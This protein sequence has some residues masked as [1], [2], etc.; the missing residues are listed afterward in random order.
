MTIKVVYHNDE[1]DEVEPARL[2]ELI[3]SHKIKKFLRTKGWATVGVDPVRGAR[4]SYSGPERRGR[5]G[6][7]DFL[8][9]DLWH[10]TEICI[11]DRSKSAVSICDFETLFESAPAMML[12]LNPDFRIVAASNAYLQHTNTRREDI[13]DHDVFDILPA[14]SGDPK[15]SGNRGLRV[16]LERVL[17]S[18]KPHAM[19]MQ[20]HALPG[21]G[22]NG[23][24][25]GKRYWNS[26]N[27]PV[28][29]PDNTVKYIIHRLEDITR[30]EHLKA[31]A[32][33]QH[34]LIEAL[35][36]F[37]IQVGSEF[38]AKAREAT[39]N[40]LHLEDVIARLERENDKLK[41]LVES[42]N[43][44]IWFYDQRDN[45]LHVNPAIVNHIGLE[46]CGNCG[47]E[48]VLAGL[49]IYHPNGTPR[50]FEESPVYRA[51]IEREVVSGEEIVRHL[52]TGEPRYRQ[53]TAAPMRDDTGLV[54]GAVAV[55][56][57][58]TEQ[59][60]LM[61]ELQE[62]LARAKLLSGMLPI[63]SS[64]KRIKDDKGIWTHVE[65]YI[66]DHSQADFT[67]SLCPDCARKLYPGIFCDER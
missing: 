62:K 33:E 42:V 7:A 59:R 31:K 46:L 1:T 41:V 23:K 20:T 15:P 21:S 47:L 13:I 53:Y 17:R 6:Q 61:L 28:L 43:D 27:T 49:E 52:K 54:F 38:Y 26:V 58:I 48:D 25:F 35:R 3:A 63:C 8:K 32:V 14:Y 50:R 2:D 30:E 24:N 16:S 5:E 39:E 36:L 4:G 22:G 37:V 67:H 45:V 56:R 65:N 64:C 51:I 9:E 12:V 10:R 60:M 40:N 11:S 34:K 66:H 18:R 29:G 44:E 57:D 55:V 19:A